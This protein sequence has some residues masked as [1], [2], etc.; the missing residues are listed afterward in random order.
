M[1]N[2]KENR[3]LEDGYIEIVGVYSALKNFHSFSNKLS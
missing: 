2:K 1:N 3:K